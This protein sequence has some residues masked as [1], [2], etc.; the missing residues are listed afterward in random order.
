MKRRLQVPLAVWLCLT[1]S[2]ATAGELGLRFNATASIPLGV[3]WLQGQLPNRGAYVAACLPDTVARQA[4]A[5]GYIGVGRC[6]GGSQELLKV[7]A[8]AAGDH[9]VIDVAGVSVNGRRWP[10]SA[11]RRADGQ[12][13]ALA[14]AVG[15]SRRLQDNEALLMSEGCEDGFDS[16]YFGPLPVSQ[17]RGTARPL[18]LMKDLPL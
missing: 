8:A 4:M 17:L 10:D 14:S 6:A 15:L 18:L 5:R 3:Y 1:A 2:L 7:V 16:R 9:V 13:R 12:G 11:V